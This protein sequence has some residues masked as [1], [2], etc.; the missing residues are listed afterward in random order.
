[1]VQRGSQAMDKAKLDEV[2]ECR[3]QGYQLTQKIGS[4]SFSRV[5]LGIP[6]QEKICCNF[7][8]AVGLQNKKEKA[9]AIKVIPISQTLQQQSRRCLSREINALQS[10][11]KHPN[12]I[13]L[14]E[15]F[16]SPS[17]LYLVL[18]LAVKGDLLE[19]INRLSDRKVTLQEQEAVRLFTELVGAVSHCH[20]KNIVHRDLKCE[21]ILLDERGSLKLTDFGLA[22]RY[23]KNGLMSTFCGS[24]PYMAPEILQ[25]QKY[26]GEHADIWSMGVILYAMVTGKLPFTEVQPSK[27]LEEIKYGILYHERLSTDCQDLISKMLQW[28]PSARPTLSEVLTHPWMLPTASILFQKVR[29]FMAGS[30]DKKQR[31][32]T[33]GK[34]G[35]HP[36]KRNSK[37]KKVLIICDSSVSKVKLKM[38]ATKRQAN[39]SRSSPQEQPGKGP[40]PPTSD[41]D[42]MVKLFSHV[43]RPPA[44]AKPMCS[45]K[46]PVSTSMQ[47]SELARKLRGLQDGGPC[48]CLSRSRQRLTPM[49]ESLPRQ[50]K[51]F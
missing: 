23:R 41:A 3:E 20:S 44:A 50:L 19:H 16:R 15:A 36:V 34:G 11:Y 37:G 14:Y 2:S 39:L 30:S 10:T 22:T 35:S 47:N 25:G 40:V 21:N 9:V 45:F 43:P 6:T 31:K 49:A 8:L 24:M 1:M 38:E 13:Q 33:T 32:E 51:G 17:R 26:K 5:Y 27:L 12:V 18:E 42:R 46:R 28:K 7:R 48:M 4:G 29:I